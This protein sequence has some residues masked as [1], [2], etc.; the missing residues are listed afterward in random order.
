MNL[1]TGVPHRIAAKA[2]AAD[3][4]ATSPQFT[5]QVRGVLIAARFADRKEQVHERFPS[6]GPT[7]L[8]S[9][10]GQNDSANRGHYFHGRKRVK[11]ARERWTHLREEFTSFVA[12]SLRD[13]KAKSTQ[14]VDWLLQVEHTNDA[15]EAFGVPVA[16]RQGYL[17]VSSDSA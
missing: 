14:T 16:E 8:G 7:I 9:R 6:R 4:R 2:D 15:G 12:L 1:A 11:T 10:L 3:I 13:R 17:A 5:D